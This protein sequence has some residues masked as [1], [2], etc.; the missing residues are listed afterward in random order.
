MEE[1]AITAVDCLTKDP[2]RLKFHRNPLK[3]V[4]NAARAIRKSPKAQK[5]NSKGKGKVAL[6][7]VRLEWREIFLQRIHLILK[8]EKC[9][10]K[11]LTLL[12][13]RCFLTNWKVK[14]ITRDSRSGS[15]HSNFLEGKNPR[16]TLTMTIELWGSL[17]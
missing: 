5:K 14:M 4:T 17:R 9:Q 3:T 11:L 6:M 13:V 2:L 1:K 16:M 7:K 8:I 15:T 12:N 10:V